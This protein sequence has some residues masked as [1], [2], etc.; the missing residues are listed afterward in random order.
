MC[1][2]SAFKFRRFMPAIAKMIASN[3]P[4]FSFLSLVCTFPRSEMIS[5]SGLIISSCI[6]RRRLVVPTFAPCGR[7]LNLANFSLIIASLVS[8]REQ[9]A[10]S[11]SPSGKTTG[12]SF[13]LCTAMSVSPFSMLSSSSF[14]KSPLPPIFASGVSRITSPFVFMPSSTTF[15]P[16]CCASILALICSLCQ[17]AKILFLVAIF[18]SFIISPNLLFLALR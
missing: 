15:M 9:M 13:R 2:T 5:R 3:S 12:T 18:I 1:A 7:S 14:V 10:A 17:S 4:S 6:L 16:L 11:L 8:S